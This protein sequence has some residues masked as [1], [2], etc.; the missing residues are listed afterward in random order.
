ME[1][2]NEDNNINNNLDEDINKIIKDIFDNNDTDIDF[3]N[4]CN[5]NDKNYNS[6]KDEFEMINIEEDPSFDFL[7]EQNLKLE[8][9]YD[10]N[11]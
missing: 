6:E 5:K 1:V 10:E 3:I 2:I 4:L 9:G 7:S 8:K 11:L